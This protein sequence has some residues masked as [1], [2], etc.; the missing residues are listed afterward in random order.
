MYL[1]V[2]ICLKN[3]ILLKCVEHDPEIQKLKSQQGLRR[4]SVLCTSEKMYFQKTNSNAK[5]EERKR[6]ERKKERKK[7][8]RRNTVLCGEEEN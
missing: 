8:K 4:N 6:E 7:K 2:Y 3:D 5:K 1:A